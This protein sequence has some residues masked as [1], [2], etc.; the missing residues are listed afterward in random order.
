L[1]I[2]GFVLS[3]MWLLVGCAVPWWHTLYGLPLFVGAYALTARGRKHPAPETSRVVTIGMSVLA[4]A[5]V[6]A[7]IVWSG[8]ALSW[9]LRR[10]G[11]AFRADCGDTGT[12]QHMH[13][14]R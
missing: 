8:Y 10:H 4:G 2:V 13:A 12:Q 5:F 7:N 14:C 11:T 3:T 1:I 6:A 9:D